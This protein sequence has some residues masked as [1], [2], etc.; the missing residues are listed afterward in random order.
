MQTAPGQSG[1]PAS[2][3]AACF[4][5]F[6]V[7]RQKL[8][9]AARM[10][11]GGIRT[12]R[13]YLCASASHSSAP[14]HPREPIM[15]ESALSFEGRSCE[16]RVQTP[17]R[18]LRR[19][20]QG[21]ERFAETARIDLSYLVLSSFLAFRLLPY[22]RSDVRRPIGQALADDALHGAF[23]A[24]HVI[25][26][27][28]N[29]IAIA[30]VELRKVAVQVLFLAMLID[31]LHA[32]LKNRVVA[33]NGV[34]VDRLNVELVALDP[35]L[36]ANVLFRTMLHGLVAS[37]VVRN[38][39][40][41]LGFVGHDGRF[42]RNVLAHDRH[43]VG[44]RIA[45]NMEAA[46]RTAA[47]HKSKNRVLVAV[48]LGLG[49]APGRRAV[50]LTNVGLIRLHDGAGPAH[51]LNANNAHSLADA[52]RHEPGGLE[53]DAQGAMELVAAD[54]LLAGA[55]QVHRLQP[56]VHGDVAG[57]EDGPDLHG[58]LLPALVALPKA[59]TGGF[60]A[61]LGDALDS[62]AVRADRAFRPHAGL[63]P[64]DSVGFVL[65]DAGG[66][67]RIGHDTGFQLMIQQYHGHLGLAS[68]ISPGGFVMLRRIAEEAAALTSLALFLGM[69]A[70]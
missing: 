36:I 53:S 69:V 57:L 6:L 58:E 42:A 7:R 1:R 59:D 14:L 41:V 26:A 2:R 33:L 54:A 17:Q 44:D 37:E 66:K 31:T 32:A 45:V 50:E 60:A 9:L 13:R 5:F 12:R 29:A 63:N 34:G 51:G 18:F 30:E 35:E 20:R 39:V 70:I 16:R 68:T 55:K 56:Q 15:D 48:A 62:A 43:D 24:L 40:V 19:Q 38:I 28:P 67:D 10:M 8:R 65:Q 47:L 52:V 64:R 49:A 46:G 25:Y 4:A 61:H 11:D 21:R 22:G 3:M 23:G 27:Q